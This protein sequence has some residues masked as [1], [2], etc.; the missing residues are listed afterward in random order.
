MENENLETYRNLIFNKQNL[1][2]KIPDDFL[3][4]GILQIQFGSGQ[5]LQVDELVTPNADN[6]G[7]GLPFEQNK[8]GV[9]LTLPGLDRKIISDVYVYWF[10]QV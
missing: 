3:N 6:V 1:T 7:I 4:E 8:W 5:P 10:E 9:R 2:T